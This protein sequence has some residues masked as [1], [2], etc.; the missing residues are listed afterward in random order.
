MGIKYFFGW[1]KNTFPSHIKTLRMN[2]NIKETVDVDT[3]L[4][5]MNG[6]FHYCCQKVYCYG[7][8]KHL[9]TDDNHFLKKTTSQKK[10]KILFEMIGKYL[11][12]LILFVKPN[13]RVVLAIDG[14]APLSKQNQQRSRRYRSAKDND[15]GVFDSNTITPGTLFMDQLTRYIDWYIRKQMSNGIW[16]D[17]EIIFSP[18]KAPG[19]GEHKLVKFVREHCDEKETFMMQG[20]DA[21]LVMLSLATHKPNFHVLRENPYRYEYEY[22]YIDLKSIREY[23]VNA[24]LCDQSLL[25]DSI[26]INDFITMIF[27]TGNDF[28]PHIP[29]IGILDGGVDVLLETYRMVVKQYG[30]LTTITSRLNTN[31]LHVFL[32]TLSQHEIQFLKDKRKK[33]CTF[34][35]TLLE[36]HTSLGKDGEFDIDFEAY[37]KQYYLEKMNCKS[38]D[39]IRLACMRYIDGIQWVLTYYTEGVSNWKWFYPYDYAPFLS[40]LAMYMEENAYDEYCAKKAA[41]EPSH[42]KPY[43]PYLQLLCVLPPKSKNLLPESLSQMMTH[44]RLS[45]FYPNEFTIDLDGKMN[46]WEG[47]VRLPLLNHSLIEKEY[48][49]KIKSLED[50]DKKRNIIGKTMKYYKNDIPSVFKSYYGDLQEC[51][52]N[53]SFI[54]L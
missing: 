15:D 39:E 2:E 40:D 6:I 14:P 43:S 37:K 42:Y 3:F 18:E 50:K 21:D 36:K 28:L 7:N 17:I 38:D 52:I 49:T 48:Y 16:G 45:S 1:L 35:D 20:M 23:L 44:P 5:D 24:L 32:G 29:T 4:I 51:T 26:H 54:D 11:D 19:E 47:V 46:Q 31:A 53:Y 33:S 13:R 41:P 12:K 22:F 10:Q 25:D 34:P 8:F 30:P 27:L 9:N